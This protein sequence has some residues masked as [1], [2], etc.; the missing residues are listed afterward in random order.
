MK[1]SQILTK[2]CKEG[3]VLYYNIDELIDNA[4]ANIDLDQILTKLCDKGKVLLR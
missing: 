3:K 1:P 2:L 4:H